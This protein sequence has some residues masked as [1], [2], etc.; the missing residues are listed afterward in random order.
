MCVCTS[1]FMCPGVILGRR[2]QCC[3]CIF[4]SS[5]VSLIWSICTSY[6]NIIFRL[7]KD[8]H[9]IHTY[10][11]SHV[12]CWCL[13]GWSAGQSAVLI[14]GLGEVGGAAAVIRAF[15]CGLAE[16]KG[17]LLN[18][19]G[20]TTG[21]DRDREGWTGG[22]DCPQ[23]WWPWLAGLCMYAQVHTCKDEWQTA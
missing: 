6:E 12:K 19:S 7:F 3:S 21:R 17:H 20:R 15:W 18:I 16:R 13:T 4:L 8:T 1:V 10:T 11:E 22:G 23:T 14:I 9:K 2:P 5:L